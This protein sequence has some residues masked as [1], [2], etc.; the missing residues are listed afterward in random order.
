MGEASE[1]IQRALET[2]IERVRIRGEV[3]NFREVNRNWYF[4]LKDDLAR[5]DAIMLRMDQRGCASP[6]DGSSVVVEGRIGHYAK[7]G[8]TQIRCDAME[9]AGAGDLDAR[10]RALHAELAA[11]GL[12]DAS[13][14]RTPPRVPNR[15]VLITSRG[16]AAEADVLHAL[17]TRAPGARMTCVDVRV[18]GELAVP[19]VCAALEAASAAGRHGEADVVLLVRGGGSAE[20]LWAF[21]EREVAEAIVGCSV[22]VIV[23]VGHEIDLTIA[24]AVADRTSPT[25]SRAATDHFASIDELH[26]DADQLALRLREAVR[27]RVRDCERSIGAVARHPALARPAGLVQ[28]RIAELQQRMAALLRA[29]HARLSECAGRHARGAVALEAR[30]PRTVLAHCSARLEAH[31]SALARAARV[32]SDRAAARIGSMSERLDSVGPAR[33][34]SRGYSI[35]LASDG[36][37]VRDAAALSA[38]DE[39]RTV[40]SRGSVRSRV[41]G[42]EAARADAEDA[43]RSP[44]ARH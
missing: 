29:T 20:D 6:A 1:R 9:A 17:S 19:Q 10:K 22:P 30:H 42:V 18:Q 32:R 33:V 43:P 37:V 3:M 4:S 11:R 16:S 8:R 38:G 15:I 28:M 26:S 12:L 39:L 7:Q 31:A 44:T 34:L 35:T 41:Q 2:G 27:E 24:D 5:I 13:R 36:T 23:G 21:N 14:K 25:P 40:L